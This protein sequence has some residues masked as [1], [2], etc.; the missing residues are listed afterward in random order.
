MKKYIV[1]SGDTFEIIARKQ[2]GDENQVSLIITA[3]PGVVEPLSVGTSIVIP[4]QPDAPQIIP[5]N[6]PS[7][8]VNEVALKIDNDR[9]RF[10]E[11]VTI[12][13]SI[14]TFDTLQFT[15]P[16]QFENEGFREIFRPFSF[17]NVSLTIGGTPLFKGTMLTPIPSLDDNSKTVAVSGY[18]LP[19]VL[20]DCTMP[21]SAFPL[22]FDGQGLKDISKT[23]AAFFGLSVEFTE[24]QGPVF[25]RV[26]SEPNKNALPFLIKLAQQRNFVISS[27]P[28]GKLLFQRSIEK[29]NPVA[30]LVQ[31]ES[32]IL[33]ITPRFNPQ[34]Y[35]SHI[36]GLQP[37]SVVG[38]GSKHT[39]KNPRLEGIIRPH[40]FK[41]NDTTDGNIK[42][43]T[44]AKASRMFANI[45]SYD[46]A[47]PT[48]RDSKDNLWTPNTTITLIA[49]GSMVY[50]EYEFLIRSV[51]LTRDA[52]SETA[53]LNLVIRESFNGEMPESLPWD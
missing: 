31:G 38:S 23:I 11:K 28:E 20:N 46:L 49:P 18:S 24:Q 52:N 3:N 7:D 29:G 4:D 42:E 37:S 16:F 15:A 5:Q 34:G 17:K 30:R 51:S 50:S 10:W 32:P 27:T 44:E 13:R 8:S 45:A 41:P 53:V 47:I 21:S 26:A 39:V 25:D 36:T 40:T 9:F 12:T 48:W 35:F 43:A 33:S 6:I 22:E 2:Y 1:Q 19:G 14:D